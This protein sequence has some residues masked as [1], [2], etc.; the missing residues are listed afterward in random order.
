[1][2][3]KLYIVA[4]IDNK[5]WDEIFSCI[6]FAAMFSQNNAANIDKSILDKIRIRDLD[7]DKYVKKYIQNWLFKGD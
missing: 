5:D 2:T 1:M 7:Q 6:R 4:G 3:K